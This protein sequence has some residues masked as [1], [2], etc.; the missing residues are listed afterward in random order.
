MICLLLNFLSTVF[1]RRS[2]VYFVF[3]CFFLSS[4]SQ[5]YKY[6]CTFFKNNLSLGSFRWD[7]VQWRM[8][9]SSE[10]WRQ[11]KKH[12]Q[13][14]VNRY[15]L[16]WRKLLCFSVGIL[17]GLFF[18][19]SVSRIMQKLRMNFVKFLEVVDVWKKRSMACRIWGSSRSKFLLV[20]FSVHWT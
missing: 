13:P 3:F 15:P 8:S 20:N 16:W 5:V 1:S 12:L 9:T 2:F 10:N 14:K 6:Y 11:V 17:F 18:C 7:V 4:S 19:L